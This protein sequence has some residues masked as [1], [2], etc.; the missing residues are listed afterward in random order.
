MFAREE[1]EKAPL[2]LSAGLRVAVVL[3]GFLTLAIGVYPSRFCN[4]RGR[5]C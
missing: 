4:W 2:A 5:R 3:S 1:T